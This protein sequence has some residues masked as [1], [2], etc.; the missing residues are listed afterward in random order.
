MSWSAVDFI[1]DLDVTRA[2][3]VCVLAANTAEKFFP[4]EDPLGK[5]I[6]VRQVPYVVVGVNETARADGRHRQFDRSP[7]F[8]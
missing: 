6:R 8:H 7:G 2:D 4:L 3:S 5:T 1:G